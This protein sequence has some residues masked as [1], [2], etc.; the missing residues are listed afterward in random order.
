M[1]D[2]EAKL[3]VELA[4]FQR[5]VEKLEAWTDRDRQDPELRAEADRFKRRFEGFEKRV[6]AFFK[7]SAS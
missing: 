3:R 6:A 1:T 2:A 5:E 4:K 7:T